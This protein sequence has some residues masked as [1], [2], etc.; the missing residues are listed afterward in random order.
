MKGI[1]LINWIKVA[2]SPTLLLGSV[3]LA[4]M[5]SM[6]DDKLGLY[7]FGGM[8]A[9]GILLGITWANHVK[10]KYGTTHFISRVDA[11]EDITEY[12]KN[13]GK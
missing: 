2:L 6:E 11:S 10:K 8:V 13:R 3:G 5:L 7:I 1:E 9:V 4:L 12:M